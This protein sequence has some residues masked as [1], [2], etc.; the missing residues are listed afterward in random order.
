MEAPSLSNVQETIA[1]VLA[2]E[3]GTLTEVEQSQIKDLRAFGGPITTLEL[4]IPSDSPALHVSDGLD[5]EQRS[6]VDVVDG[7]GSIVGGMMLCV[8][9]GRLSDLEYY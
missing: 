3:R 5:P 6:G 4:D 9:G 8:A 1:R 7:G 2:I